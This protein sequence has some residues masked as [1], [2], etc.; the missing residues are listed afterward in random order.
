MSLRNF[1]LGLVLMAAGGAP[2]VAT[3]EDDTHPL[4][5]RDLVAMER[6]GAPQLG[7]DA[8]W[9]LFE[10][11]SPDLPANKLV[12][13]VWLLDRTQAGAAPR[14]LA[15]G[16]QPRWSA[17]GT[18]IY[19]LA[20]AGERMQV[21]RIAPDGGTALQVTDL[22]LDVEGFR[23]APDGRHLALALAVFPEC[24]GEI[25]CTRARLNARE[26]DKASGRVYDKLFVRHWDSWAD[27][28]RNQIFL[29]ALD[30]E[31]KAG[32]PRLL[33][34]GVDGDVPSKPF[35]DDSEYVF[36][37][38]GQW[39]YF[40]VRIAG[41]D[42]PW[43]TNFDIYRVAT[44]GDAAPENLSAGNPAWDGY[45]L[46]SPDGGTLYWLAMKRPGFEAD[47][48]GIM[49]LDLASGARREVAPRW[50]RSAGP[51]AISA[52]GA[53]L[54]TTADE[55]G[56]HPLF[57]VR[58]RDGAVTRLSG[59]G[60]VRG[61]AIGDDGA[62]VVAWQDFTHPANLYRIEPGEV[63]A[64]LTRFNAARLAHL[65]MGQAEFF[66]FK[67]WNG[68][69]VQ[70]YVMQ[71][72]DFQP[73]RKYPVAFL[74]HGGPQ[75]AWTNE[76]HYRWNP[77]AYAGAGFAVVAINFHGSTGYG[78][79]FTDA[80]SGDWGGKPLT[81]LKLGWA[82]ALK[83][84]P[85]LDAG[86]ACALGASYGGYMVYWM[87][88]KW[89]KPWKCFVDHDGVFDSRSMYYSTEELWF[90]E[91]EHRGPEYQHPQHY[92]KFNPLRHVKDWRVPML[93]IHGGLDFR[94]PD[95]QGLA[96]FT[97]LQRRGIPSEFLYFPDE[98]HWVVKPA[99]SV[100]W[101][102]TVL[103]WMKRWTAAE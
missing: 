27:G 61:F 5:V 82:A 51:L 77:Q 38:D 39:L 48:F 103:N 15:E 17:D 69:P 16:S 85:F 58:V 52:D 99:N 87:A 36:S 79:A 102:D 98:N 78:Q 25:A 12:T 7:K 53:T 30:A 101:H 74:I 32:A 22:P 44:T 67:G 6:V 11:R 14:K 37:P 94:I 86:R 43:R 31:G 56:Q 50:D 64:Q 33:T 62:I 41:H 71:P 13:G 34:R 83:K 18:A 45:P 63:L 72:A 70:G 29:A 46:L 19:Y 76:F 84:Y 40:N 20:K 90:E 97:A 28:R 80:I 88:G 92:E 93:V 2:A 73:G 4:D 68:E 57:A 89:N 55:A 21:F 54:Y 1:A 24:K 35:G 9:L 59:E 8:R 100:L 66:S 96:A 49:A 60:T 26:A 95:T 91:W 75:G 65:R 23:V 10:V 47:R 3:A 81:D 42:E